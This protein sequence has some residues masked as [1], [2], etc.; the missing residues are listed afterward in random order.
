MSI[1]KVL[2]EQGKTY[3]GLSITPSG[4]LVASGPYIPED[5]QRLKGLGFDIR[6]GT[7]P[8]YLEVMKVCPLCVQNAQAQAWHET[9]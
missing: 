3:Y 2:I 1:K 6:E 7:V 4:H 5:A 8:H 9:F